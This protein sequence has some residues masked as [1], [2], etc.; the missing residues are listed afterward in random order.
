MDGD[1]FC[2]VTE[3]CEVSLF[4]VYFIIVSKML[5]LSLHCLCIHFVFHESIYQ[6]VYPSIHPQGGDLD[7]M[8]KQL[9]EAGKRL[10]ESLIMDWFVQLTNAVRYIHDRYTIYHRGVSM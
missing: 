9:K 5:P 4:N 1:Y 3:Y 10:G 7:H 6:T 2:I 8:I